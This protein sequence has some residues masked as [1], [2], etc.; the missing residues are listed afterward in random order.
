[1]H[2]SGGIPFAGLLAQINS[3]KPRS[4][5]MKLAKL[6]TVV[7]V[8]SLMASMALA[9]PPQGGGGRGQGGRG[10]QGMQGLID[11]AL[12]PLTDAID[13]LDLTDDQKTK[14]ADL[15]KEYEPKF[16]DFHDKMVAVLTDDQKKTL[17]DGKKKVADATG[18]ERMTAMR[19]LMTSLSI[20]DDERTKM[21]EIGTEQQPVMREARTK[22][23]GVLTDELK[24]KMPQMGGGRGGRGGNRGGGNGGNGGTTQSREST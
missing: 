10:G 16:K 14:I 17:E 21:R 24:A 1:M 20:T 13:K 5:K 12:K 18:R 19:D 6:S 7:A 11:S 9:Q 4:V 3:L 23:M 8:F 22:F 15:K 2:V